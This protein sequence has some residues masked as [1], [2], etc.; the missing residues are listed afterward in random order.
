MCKLAEVRKFCSE[1]GQDEVNFIKQWLF[2]T[3]F[4]DVFKS[5]F[6]IVAKLRAEREKDL[7]FEKEQKKKAKQG[8]IINQKPK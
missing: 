1:H 8:I 5:K 2:F 4:R 7:K 6:E 3:E